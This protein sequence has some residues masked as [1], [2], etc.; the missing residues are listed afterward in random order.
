MITGERREPKN[1]NRHTKLPPDCA[2]NLEMLFSEMYILIIQRGGGCPDP[3]SG[4]PSPR[5]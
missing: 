5:L 1:F 4:T 2:E 3:P